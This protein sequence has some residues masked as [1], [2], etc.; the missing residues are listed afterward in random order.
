MPGDLYLRCNINIGQD[1]PQD[2]LSKNYLGSIKAFLPKELCSS[3][4]KNGLKV[5][6]CGGL[7]SLA[8]LC[9][10]EAVNRVLNDNAQLDEFLDLCERFDHDILPDGPGTKQRAGLIAVAER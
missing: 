1:T 9:G 10:Q 2:H 4:E 5:L 8:N 3:L 6:R 7:G